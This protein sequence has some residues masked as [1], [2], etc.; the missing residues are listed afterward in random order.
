MR[1]DNHPPYRPYRD[2]WEWLFADWHLIFI[3]LGLV[4]GY[5]YYLITTTAV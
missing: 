1:I 3:P 2:F 5:F 4:P